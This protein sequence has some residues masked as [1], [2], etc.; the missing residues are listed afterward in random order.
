MMPSSAS[1]PRR[2]Q[3]PIS[4]AAAMVRP[5]PRDRL[6]SG[7][8][9]RFFAEQ[10]LVVSPHVQDVH[11]LPFGVDPINQPVLN[12]DPAGAK[13]TQITDLFLE[14]GRRL[15]RVLPQNVT[16]CLRL[17]LSPTCA[18]FLASF[19]AC[20]LGRPATPC[21]G[22]HHLSFSSSVPFS[23]GSLAALWMLSTRPGI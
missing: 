11:D 21:A 12:I 19:T 17:V 18:S 5:A 22:V 23:N 10:S 15:E 9:K 16:Q 20:H 3:P 2:H 7:H 14:A 4:K 8:R 1:R 6:R 13:T